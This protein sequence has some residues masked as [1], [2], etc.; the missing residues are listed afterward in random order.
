MS[1]QVN[2]PAHY[3]SHPSGIE[4]ID[5]IRHYTFDIGCAIKYMWRAGLKPEMGK[6]DADKEIEDLN[7]A[8]W[9]IEDYLNSSRVGGS[10]RNTAKI[11]WGNSS[12]MDMLVHHETGYKPSDIVKGY[13]EHVAAAMRYLLRVGLVSNSEV[14]VCEGWLLE[15]RDAQRHIRARVLHIINQAISKEASDVAAV[16]SGRSVEG[17]HY[18]KPGGQRKD[19]PDKYDPLNMVII[20]GSAY[21][22]SDEI[23]EKGGGAVED[24]CKLCALS[25]YCVRLCDMHTAANNEY[26]KNVGEV[27]YSPSFGTIEVYDETK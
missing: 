24:P 20:E 9:Y 23:K 8:L 19:E 25:D 27:R 2:H 1:E 7:K 11:C 6:D 10:L 15:L 13:D 21:C 22:L 4:C 5:V 17:V 3:N 18:A 26:Y 14:L 16:L 12:A